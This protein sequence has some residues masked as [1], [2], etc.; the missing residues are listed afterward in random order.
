MEQG[1]EGRVSGTGEGRKKGREDER[2]KGREEDLDT[3]SG[4]I[5]DRKVSARRFDQKGKCSDITNHA[6]QRY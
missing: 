2:K 5:R 4:M 6:R 1:Q 3:D